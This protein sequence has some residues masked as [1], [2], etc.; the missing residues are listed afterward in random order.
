[1]GSLDRPGGRRWGNARRGQ[2]LGDATELARRSLGT[3]PDDGARHTDAARIAA[4]SRA[5]SVHDAGA[6]GF[7][8][9]HAESTAAFLGD[10]P[11][12]HDVSRGGSRARRASTREEGKNAGCETDA[13]DPLLRPRDGGDAAGDA[14]ARI[15]ERATVLPFVRST[16]R[17]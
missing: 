13:V 5:E 14:V 1:M 6:D 11:R 7:R 2:G 9:R 8:R 4:L 15:A 10:G 12:G 17:G 3:G 16:S